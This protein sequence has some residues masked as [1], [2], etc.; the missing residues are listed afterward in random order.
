[1]SGKLKFIIKTY[2]LLCLLYDSQYQGDSEIRHD[3]DEL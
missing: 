1:M 2:A 3:E